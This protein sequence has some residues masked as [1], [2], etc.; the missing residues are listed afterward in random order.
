MEKIEIEEIISKED[1]IKLA[2]KGR[3]LMIRFEEQKDFFAKINN[4]YYAFNQV[5]KTYQLIGI[6]HKYN[7]NERI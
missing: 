5:N 4:A 7:S 6:T 3:A 1:M 2:E